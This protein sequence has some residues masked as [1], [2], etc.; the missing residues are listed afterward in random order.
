MLDSSIRYPVSQ[1]LATLLKL[2]SEKS[3]G[4]S[5]RQ[6]FDWLSSSL[7][8]LFRFFFLFSLNIDKRLFVS[9]SLELSSEVILPELTTD[10]T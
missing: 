5:H 4:A 1:E 7:S 3:L 2:E 10:S 8:A 9:V 6:A